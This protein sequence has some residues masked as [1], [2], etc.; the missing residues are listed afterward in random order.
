MIRRTR[1]FS[2]CSLPQNLMRLVGS[3]Y[4]HEKWIEGRAGSGRGLTRIT[5]SFGSR[6]SSR[7][8]EKKDIVACL[9]LHQVDRGDKRCKL[10]SN[11]RYYMGNPTSEARSLLI[12][13]RCSVSDPITIHA[14]ELPSCSYPVDATS[15]VPNGPYADLLFPISL[16]P[17]AT[18]AAF[19]TSPLTRQPTLGS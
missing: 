1:T 13:S 12:L 2:T 16:A 7:P 9:D 3:S 6:S 10:I 4:K 5:K 17:P 18:N 19:H 14:S 11:D 15:F 8:K